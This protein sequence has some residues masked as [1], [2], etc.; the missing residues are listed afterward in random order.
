MTKPEVKSSPHVYK[1]KYEQNNNLC[2]LT[3]I[4]NNGSLI[5]D[6]NAGKYWSTAFPSLMFEVEEEI[7]KLYK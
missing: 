4:Y 1:I 7:E 3:L 6:D 2:E 5:I